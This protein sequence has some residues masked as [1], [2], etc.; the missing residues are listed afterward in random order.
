[1]EYVVG[2]T[3]QTQTILYQFNM[4]AEITLHFA[5]DLHF[6]LFLSALT[7]DS[8]VL[9]RFLIYNVF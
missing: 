7:Y 6:A 4:L 3:F 2:R 1:M 9:T 8:M 5:L